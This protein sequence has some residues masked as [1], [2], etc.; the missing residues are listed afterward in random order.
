MQLVRDRLPAKYGF[1]PANDIQV[2]CPMNVQ[3]LGTR[4]FNEVL[5]D[6][7]NPPNEMKF[8]VE[9]F[10]KTFRVG[11]KVIQTRNNYDKEVFNGDIGHISSIESQPVKII[12]TYDGNR[13]VNYEP[14]ELD[15]LQPAY[16]IT[17]HKSQGSEFPCVIIPLAMAHF[18]MLER[19]LIYTAVTRGKKLVVIVG[20]SKALG[21][22]VRQAGAR[23]RWTGL[24]ERLA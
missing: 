13:R 20:E 17:I 18:V 21:M 14:G 24:K 16:A 4:A 9:R 15:E 10:E 2:L 5:Q 7:L 1:D 12:V 19:S 23:K 3:L 11:D 8:E 6:A 22:A